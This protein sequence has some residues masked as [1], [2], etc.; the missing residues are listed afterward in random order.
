MCR[1][2]AA[3]AD[4]LLSPHGHLR[5]LLHNRDGDVPGD[6]GDLVPH[7]KTHPERSWAIPYQP[8]GPLEPDQAAA[9]PSLGGLA[10][11]IRGAERE[12]SAG[13]KGPEQLS[14]IKLVIS[15]L[16]LFILNPSDLGRI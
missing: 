14:E 13:F 10:G 4:A 15:G 12:G 8:P 2:A 5:P 9:D 11:R 3:D 6:E 1:H 7:C 16:S